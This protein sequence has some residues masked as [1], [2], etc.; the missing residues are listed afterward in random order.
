L[1]R[2]RSRLPIREQGTPVKQLDANTARPWHGA[3]VCLVLAGFYAFLLAQHALVYLCHD[4]WG[5]A[6]L[7]YVSTQTGFAGRDFTLSHALRYVAEVYTVWAGRVG[8]LLA[9]AY[10]QKA[11][12]GFVQVL[13]P[14]II[15]AAGVLCLAL[16]RP[17]L[18]GRWSLLGAAFAVLVYA[19]LPVRI[20]VAG[21]YWYSASSV[22]LWGVPIFLAG[23]WLVARTGRV[24]VVAALLLAASATFHE[25]L[26]MVA[27]CFLLVCLGFRKWRDQEPV[28]GALAP[29]ALVLVVAALIVF[30]PG[31]LNRKAFNADFYA[32]RSV[33]EIVSF[34][35][36]VVARNWFWPEVRNLSFLAWL[37]SMLFLVMAVRERDRARFRRMAAGGG[38]LA[39][40]L[41]ACYLAGQPLAF[42]ALLLAGY[43]VVLYL[44]ALQERAGTVVFAV[45]AAAVVSS[46]PL[47]Y[48]PE[49]PGRA[50][51]T[52]FFL[53]MAPFTYSA[54]AAQRSLRPAVQVAVVLV[55]AGLALGNVAY[56]YQGYSA[57][58]AVHESNNA[59]LRAA[60]Q[61]AREGEA[62]D[63]VVLRKLPRPRFA[64]VMPYERPLIE[65]W[66]K[67]YYRLPPDTELQWRPPPGR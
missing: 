14:T 42:A 37:S 3:A 53:L 32:A 61:V 65:R 63:T 45:F 6:V 57:N 2:T 44:G 67:K 43:G 36:G 28:A 41:A 22:Y 20:L 5:I 27:V 48:A 58:A 38:L 34:N 60:G 21:V 23:A 15:L 33:W 7:D 10:A 46:L 51:V 25:V 11:G 54:A 50:G 47:L 31:N 26:A 56:V 66:M 8:G 24:G 64:E 49:V 62:P 13:Q 52:F 16:A 29:A 12:L 9:H 40:L 59:R 39:A 1:E 18:G 4:D 17:A 19:L 30:A 55:L 35:A